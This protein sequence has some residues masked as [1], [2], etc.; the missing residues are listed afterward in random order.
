MTD[1][2]EA[3]AAEPRLLEHPAATDNVQARLTAP[4]RDCGIEELCESWF[5]TDIR[6]TIASAAKLVSDPGLPGRLRGAFGAQLLEAAS[7]EAAAGHPCPWSPP[8]AFDMLFR[9]QGRME[10]GF[11]FPG[12]WVMLLDI[13][14]QDLIVTL[15]LLGFAGDYAAP[16]A[17][18]LVTAIRSRLDLP[19]KSGFFVPGREVKSRSVKARS[20]LEI[21]D[22]PQ[23]V[24][25]EF[26]TPVVLSG[27]SPLEYPVSLL[28]SMVVRASGLA[29]W[30]DLCL[31]TDRD[32]LRASLN[33]AAFEWSDTQRVDWR[34]GSNRQ[35]KAVPMSGYLGSLSISGP[36]EAL[37]NLLPILVLGEETLIGADVAFGC[38][39]YRLRTE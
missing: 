24:E 15:R 30:H 16:A 22:S 29:R 4:V 21:P 34:R 25:L 1:R 26:L 17:E 23:T 5:S 38:G 7:A 2:H 11:D 9:K 12:P 14:G 19:G 36:Q 33:A 13:S 6:V 8:C 39:R 32:A 35:D 3:N 27:I 31:V 20:R 37:K 10:P 18:A 28:S